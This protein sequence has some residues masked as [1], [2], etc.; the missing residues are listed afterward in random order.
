MFI[1][2]LHECI[3]FDQ[4][5]VFSMSKTFLAYVE[6]QFS[7]CIKLLRYDSGREYMSYEFKR[8]L[9]DKEIVS[10][11]SCPYTSQQNGVARRKN[12]YLLNVTR[13]L[14]IESSVPLNIGWKLCLLLSI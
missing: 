9:F 7:T 14:L 1:V 8:F 6:T 2:D 11:H 4:I 3:L 12:L 10:Q 5:E 13:T